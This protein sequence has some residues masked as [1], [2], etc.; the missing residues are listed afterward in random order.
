MPSRIAHTHVLLAAL[1]KSQ[2]CLCLLPWGR[3]VDRRPAASPLVCWSEFSDSHL[4]S[5]HSSSL[6]C[7]SVPLNH[8]MLPHSML[9]SQLWRLEHWVAA[10]S[11][12]RSPWA[13]VPLAPGSQFPEDHLCPCN[14]P[15]ISAGLLTPALTALAFASIASLTSSSRIMGSSRI[16]GG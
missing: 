5:V 2:D 6:T 11:R 13:T 8:S 1:Q 15:V 16:G 4:T 12:A 14:R 9:P 10:E 7:S 3:P